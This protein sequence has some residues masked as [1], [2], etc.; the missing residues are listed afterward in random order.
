M[1]HSDLVLFVNFGKAQMHI[2]TKYEGSMTNHKGR[3]GRYMEKSLS[4]KIQAILSQYFICFYWGYMCIFVQNIKSLWSNLW[5]GTLSTNNDKNVNNADDDRWGT[6]R[7]YIGSLAFIPNE[8]KMGQ[9]NVVRHQGNIPNKNLTKFLLV[10]HFWQVTDIVS[11]FGNW[12]FLT[13]K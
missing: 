11:S 13:Q 12:L 5:L 1:G 2:C 6:I 3:R 4:L 8:P 9:T 10:S 7:D